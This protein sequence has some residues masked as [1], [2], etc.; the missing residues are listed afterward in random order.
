M[1]DSKLRTQSMDFAVSVI[2]LVKLLKEKTRYINEGE[3]RA[4]AYVFYIN[5]KSLF[6]SVCF[7]QAK[8]VFR[9]FAQNYKP[10]LTINIK[11]I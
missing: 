8:E 3:Y 10:M 7:G 5:R 9:V 1:S 11:Q 2:N 6:V 4:L